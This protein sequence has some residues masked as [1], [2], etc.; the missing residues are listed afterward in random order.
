MLGLAFLLVLEITLI[1]DLLK[2]GSI[3]IFAKW[4]N[5]DPEQT[6]VVFR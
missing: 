4:P 5:R 3:R 1:E 2:A 6:F